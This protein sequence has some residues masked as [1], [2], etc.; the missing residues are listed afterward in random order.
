[1]KK[2]LVALLSS[3][4]LLGLATGCTNGESNKNDG[5]ETNSEETNTESNEE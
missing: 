5:T 1:M 2:G 3:I 4:M